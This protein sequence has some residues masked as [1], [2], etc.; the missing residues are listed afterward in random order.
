MSPLFVRMFTA[1]V[2]ALGASTMSVRAGTLPEPDAKQV[3]G[4]I[5]AQLAAFADDDADTAFATAT[6]AVQKAIGSSGRF[7]ALVRGAY[8]MVYRPTS[9]TFHQP[10]EDEGSVLQLVEI[11]D[12]DAKSWLAVFALE[13]Q[14]DATW[15]ISGCMVSE[16]RW[17]PA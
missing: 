2:L 11:T 1:A 3:Q 7:L 9:V 10:D 13:K 16:N 8:P 12:G 15:R 14:A 6:P 17:K 4:V 5:I